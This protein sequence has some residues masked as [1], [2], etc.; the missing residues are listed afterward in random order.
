MKTDTRMSDGYSLVECLIVLVAAATITTFAVPNIHHL[1]Q[2]WS[3]WGGK[4]VLESS[5]QWG[6]LHAV[7]SNMPLIFNIYEGGLR[8]GWIEAE[9][10]EEFLNSVRD[11]PSGVKIV[12]S[13]RRPLRFYQ[14]GNAAPAGTFVVAGPSGSYSVVVSPGG[15]IRTERN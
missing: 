12:S 10:G 4:A 6:R 7:S 3:L 1:L 15:R 5:L 9:S 2:E 11:L 14:H 13:P 8:F